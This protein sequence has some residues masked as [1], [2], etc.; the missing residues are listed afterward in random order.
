MRR[1]KPR[2]ARAETHPILCQCA[3]SLQRGRRAR[4]AQRAGVR[5]RGLR[6]SFHRRK[7]LCPVFPSR[8][9]RRKRSA[10][11]QAQSAARD[12]SLCGELVRRAGSTSGKHSFCPLYKT[13]SESALI[14]GAFGD[15][16]EQPRHQLDVTLSQKLGKD[17][18]CGCLHAIINSPVR[19]FSAERC[20]AQ[21][22]EAIPK[23][24][25]QRCATPRDDRRSVSVL[26]P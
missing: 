16:F 20:L 21:V 1:L 22:V 3:R 8:S 18:R 23:C 13:C 2:S 14:V 15:K 25:R 10:D 7:R 26:R 9:G 6:G 19:S 11:Q 5:E 17:C 12:S 24:K 4:S